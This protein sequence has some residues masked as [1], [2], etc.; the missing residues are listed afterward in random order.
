MAA[1]STVGEWLRQPSPHRLV[2]RLFFAGLGATY[3]IA[4]TSLRRQVKGLYARRG[5]LPVRELLEH[6]HDN[7]HPRERLAI[8][9][10]LLWLAHSDAALERWCRVGQVASLMLGFNLMPR[11]GALA[12]FAL[13]LS[14]HAAGRDFLSFQWDVLLL[15]TGALAI[16]FAPPGLLRG[17]DEPPS[18]LA[19]AMMRWLVF[20]LYL[21]SGASKLQSGD[22]TW[23]DLSAMQ[24]YYETAPLPTRGGWHAHQL[25]PRVQKT[26]TAAALLIE[27]LLAPMTLGSRKERLA[28]FA[29]FSSLQAGIA[30]TGNYGF[31]NLLSLLL[32]LWLLDDEALGGRAPTKRE[33]LSWARLLSEA[34][35]CAPLL[36]LSWGQLPPPVRRR[37]PER[38]ALQKLG[39]AL[40]LSSGYG[41]FA[42]MTTERA[43]ISVE[44]SNDGTH[45]NEYDFRYKPGPLERAPKQVAPHQPRLDWQMWF[46]ALTSPPSWFSRFLRRLL[47]GS[48]DVTSLLSSNPFPES[49]PRYV[50]AVL[51]RYTMTDRATRKQ[52]GRWWSRERLGLYFPPVTLSQEKKSRPTLRPVH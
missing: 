49:P 21:G 6:V 23:R 42:V 45:W 11:L 25:S 41:L 34:A 20:R 40:R 35:L 36:L 16:V 26:S 2:R 18:R 5:I 12:L 31:F 19:V 47:E 27:S 38:L 14:F 39:S 50:R 43:E 32:H 7:A 37:L 4:F 3:F 30:A 9:P 48:P 44:G 1:I 10:S 15:E 51:W 22:R 13:Y 46:A 24:H 8:V 28:A 52:T 29:L 17:R 33:Q